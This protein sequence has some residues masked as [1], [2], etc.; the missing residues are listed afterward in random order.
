ME[1]Y[2]NRNANPVSDA[3]ALEAV[4][5]IFEALPLVMSD[6]ESLEKRSRM[7]LAAQRL[8]APNCELISDTLSCARY[9]NRP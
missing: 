1:S 5:R 9:A 4:R 3:Y 2:W 6:P 7:L 8:S